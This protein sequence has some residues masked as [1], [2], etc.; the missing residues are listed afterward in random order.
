MVLLKWAV[1]EREFFLEFWKTLRCLLF[2]G[3]KTYHK[4]LAH[5]S[6][7]LAVRVDTFRGR[8]HTASSW[9]V[10]AGSFPEGV[11]FVFKRVC[12]QANLH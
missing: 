1:F 3:I 5:P 10:V 8:L 6:H 7:P 9:L 2:C 11:L 4:V 12:D